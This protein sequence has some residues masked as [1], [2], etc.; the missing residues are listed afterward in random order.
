M[1]VPSESPIRSVSN[2][3][4]GAKNHQIIQT[5]R[6]VALR[7]FI[8]SSYAIKAAAHAHGLIGDATLAASILGEAYP[9]TGGRQQPR[10]YA[11]FYLFTLNSLR[12]IVLLK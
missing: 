6:R 7:N 12:T 4:S 3:R 2:D 8:F 9:P 11:E 1:A 5:Q 10:G